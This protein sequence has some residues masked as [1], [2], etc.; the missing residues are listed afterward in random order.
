MLGEHRLSHHRPLSSIT[1]ESSD[2]RRGVSRGPGGRRP[3]LQVP[4][5]PSPAR[6]HGPLLVC[7]REVLN[8]FFQV[9]NWPD[10]TTVCCPRAAV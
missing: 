1:G 8:Y 2:R 5:R 3:P 7:L 6:V 10:Q 9:L 4:Q